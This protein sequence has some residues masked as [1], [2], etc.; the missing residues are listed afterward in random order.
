M[1]PPTSKVI[2]YWINIFFFTF[3]FCVFIADVTWG[4][5]ANLVFL[6]Y[7]SLLDN[8]LLALTAAYH[9]TQ[10][11]STNNSDS[12]IA[13]ILPV[14]SLTVLLTSTFIDAGQP[15]YALFL[16]VAKKILL[17]LFIIVDNC[18]TRWDQLFNL[19]RASL[20]FSALTVYQFALVLL[21]VY[22]I[23]SGVNVGFGLNINYIVYNVLQYVLEYI[24]LWV[25]CVFHNRFIFYKPIYT[26]TS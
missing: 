15:P 25:Y 3:S 26:L 6:S 2:G 13:H 24:F 20:V 16:Q 21:D 14:A 11:S 4:S 1:K 22:V 10:W 5:G 8:F 19:S 9:F 23:Q 18:F 17:P 7:L 12:Q